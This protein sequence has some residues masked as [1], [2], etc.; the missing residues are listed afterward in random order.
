MIFFW[1]QSFK[2]NFEF[3]VNVSTNLLGCLKFLLLHKISHQW[4]FLVLQIRLNQSQNLDIKIV[5]FPFFGWPPHHFVVGRSPTL[6]KKGEIFPEISR[7]WRT[8]HHWRHENDPSFFSQSSKHF[9][10]IFFWLMCKKVVTWYWPPVKRVSDTPGSL[11][12]NDIQND[13]GRGV[14]RQPTGRATPFLKNYHQDLLSYW[15]IVLSC[16]WGEILKCLPGRGKH[17][18]TPWPLYRGPGF[19]AGSATWNTGQT[20]Q[21][22]THQTD[23]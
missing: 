5:F 1:V 11:Q 19:L 9:T 12:G 15:K 3:N 13:L 8:C 4:C 10:T 18:H 14:L 21:R 17:L 23:S 22:N 7:T 2:L 6:A 16:F 20:T